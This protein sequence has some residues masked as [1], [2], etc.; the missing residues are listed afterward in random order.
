MKYVGNY[1]LDVRPDRIDLRDREYQPPLRSL[2][3]ECPAADDIDSFMALYT[4]E[5]GKGGDSL[6]L[7]QGKEGA[8]TGFGLA[9]TINYLLWRQA[10]IVEERDSDVAK[11]WPPLVSERMLYHLARFYDEWPGEDYEGSSCRGAV[12][13]WHKHGVCSR[14]LWPYRDRNGKARYVAPHKDW[15]ADAATKPLGVYYRIFKNSI[16]DMQAAISEVGAVYASADVHDG[17]NVPRKKASRVTH[18]NLPTIPW[19][20][21][22]QLAGGHAFALVGYNE[23][24]FIVQNSWGQGWGAR[25]FAVLTYDDWQANCTDAWVCVMGAPTRTSSPVHFVG[26]SRRREK[27]FENILPE[28]FIPVSGA[29]TADHEYRDPSVE[30]W[31]ESRAYQHSVVMANEGKVES[32]LVDTRDAVDAVDRIVVQGARRFFENGNK[33]PPRIALYA[34]GGLNSEGDSIARIRTLAPYFVENGVYPVFLTWKTGTLE[35]L[36]S[37]MQDATGRLFPSRKGWRE[38]WDAARDQAAEVLDRTLEVACGN[39][40]VKA[41]WSQMKQN[42]HAGSLRADGDRGGYLTVRALNKLRGEYPR[43]QV[44]LVGHSAG[45]ILLGHMLDDMTRKELEVRTC[46]LYAPACTVEFANR[47]YARAVEKEIL[48]RANLHL[49]MLDNERERGDSVGPYRKSLLYLVS[50]AL[51]DFHKMP[52]LGL[53]HTFESAGDGDDTWNRNAMDHVSNWRSFWSGARNTYLLNDEQVATAAEW[54]NGKISRVIDRIDSAHGSF[55][56]DVEVIDETL[57]RITGA[58][59]L[60]H[61]VENL[62]Y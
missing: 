18:E 56:N 49:H 7:D 60:E 31:G 42:A 62:R 41:V 4:G 23:R 17:W 59:A 40:G 46:T 55:D 57:R 5:V 9:A 35:S 34:H 33:N 26:G 48:K 3:P 44:H 50:R 58:T 51:E 47:H 25:G 11:S 37:I 24:G 10:F 61:A 27:D 39:L 38:V 1:K 16:T 8:C 19:Q 13:A 21:Q 43:L 6:I 15:A 12:K 52:L 22:A 29:K 2:P 20:P 36:L 30:P 45:S 14:K 54:K 53:A 28:Q 32:R